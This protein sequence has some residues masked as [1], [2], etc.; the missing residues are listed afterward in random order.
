MIMGKAS[1]L[2]QSQCSGL[3][4]DLEQSR[5]R[6]MADVSSALPFRHPKRNS[7]HMSYLAQKWEPASVIVHFT[8]C[9]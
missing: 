3:I 2:H 4:E 7:S 5:A 9:F 1:S 6:E 8:E